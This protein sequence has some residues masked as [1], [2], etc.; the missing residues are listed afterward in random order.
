VDRKRRASDGTG[1]IRARPE[2]VRAQQLI[3]ETLGLEVHLHD[4]QSRDSMYDLR[5]GPADQPLA[6]IE[7]VG[8]VNRDFTRTWN[9]GAAQGPVRTGGTTDWL[10]FLADGVA[11]EPLRR[12]G[13]WRFVR[14]ME[15]AGWHEQEGRHDLRTAAGDRLA[16]DL[17]AAG[18][19]AVYC[20][21]RAGSGI[22]HLGQDGDGGPPDYSGA[23]LGPWISEFLHHEDRADVLAKLEASG[24]AERHAFVHVAFKGAPFATWDYLAGPIDRLPANEPDLPLV[25]DQVWI[26]SGAARRD[27]AA[28]VVRWTGT[29]LSTFP[30]GSG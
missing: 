30:L 24:A 25:V 11:P 28:H 22:V 1:G 9:A 18:V 5:I 21:D 2:E 26:W 14:R 19:N 20:T 8:A 23:T 6:A 13:L 27:R 29:A 7:V 15:A 17:V 16:Q 3:T 4:D 12:R 10:V